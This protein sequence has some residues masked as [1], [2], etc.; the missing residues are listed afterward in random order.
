MRT[1]RIPDGFSAAWREIDESNGRKGKSM[2]PILVA[3]TCGAGL[4]EKSGDRYEDLARRIEAVVAKR[5]GQA[6]DA[7]L[8]LEPMLAEATRGLAV[9]PADM[10]AFKK[11]FRSSFS[12]SRHIFDALQKS[13][14]YTL[15]RLRRVDGRQRAVFRMKGDTGFNYHEYIFST[16]TDELRAQDLYVYMTGELMSQTLR[17]NAMNGFAGSK[18]F[19][20]KLLGTDREY[21]KNMDKMK[22]MKEHLDRGEFQEGLAVYAKLPKSLRSEKTYLIARL[23][24]ASGSGDNDAYVKAIEDFEKSHPGDPALDLLSIDGFLLKKDYARALASIDRLDERVGGD[25]YLDVIRANVHIEAGDP[26]KARECARRALKKDPRIDDALWSL[27][28]LSLHE[29]DWKETVALLGRLEK[30]FG[31]TIEVESVPLYE[32][33]TKSPEYARW[34]GSKKT[35][36][37]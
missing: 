31:A 25:P 11:G 1:G 22:A 7:L 10:E 32:E 3:L 20:A 36:E 21:L 9:S 13:G 19:V 24:L 35:K 28:T 29:K 14:T 33:F 15:L 23:Q 16:G 34:K 30:E 12:L 5:D 8:D 17:R 18:G 2:W 6:F 37:E 26:A 4:D 27:V